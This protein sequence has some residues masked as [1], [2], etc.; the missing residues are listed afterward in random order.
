[1]E[2]LIKIHKT[3]QDEYELA[4]RFLSA[5]MTLSG[6]NLSSREI[7]LLSFITVRGTISNITAS[8][9]FCSRY[10]TTEN[11]KNNMISSLKRR[12]LISKENGKIKSNIPFEIAGTELKVIFNVIG[13]NTESS[14]E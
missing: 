13:N 6:E 1:M 14:G 11:T 8:K 2:K 7:Q 10:D 4:E 5:L 12:G 9:D 3:Y